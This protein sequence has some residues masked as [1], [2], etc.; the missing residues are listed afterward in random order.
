MSEV[1]NLAGRHFRK[2]HSTTLV[3][4]PQALREALEYYPD[5]LRDIYMSPQAAQRYDSLAYRASLKHYFHYV[6]GSLFSQIAPQAQG[7]CATFDMKAFK[8]VDPS[9]VFSFTLKTK[10]PLIVLPHTQ[11]PGN[12]GAMIRVG[13]AAGASAIIACPGGADPLSPKVIR[14]SA[15]SI[16]HLPVITTMNFSQVAQALHQHGICLLG[17]DGHGQRTLFDKELSEFYK[18]H[19]WIFGNEAQ[20]LDTEQQ[21]ACDTLVRIPLYGKAESLNVS[22]ACSICVYESVRRQIADVARIE[23]SDR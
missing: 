7:I 5:S 8:S 14:M 1:K 23:T 17:A 9:F 22:Q 16:F 4:G 13:D 20:G 2:K 11:D 15:G 18:P 21:K 19:A 12:M 6:D 10:R 3:E